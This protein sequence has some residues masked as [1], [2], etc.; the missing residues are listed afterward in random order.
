MIKSSAEK[1]TLQQEIFKSSKLPRDNTNEIMQQNVYRTILYGVPFRLADEYAHATK[2]IQYN[3]SRRIVGAMCNVYMNKLSHGNTT[4]YGI[5]DKVK[6]INGRNVITSRGSFRELVSKTLSQSNDLFQEQSKLWEW[7]EDK[8][9]KVHPRLDT[10][11]FYTALEQMNDIKLFNRKLFDFNEY[12]GRYSLYHLPTYWSEY[13]LAKRILEILHGNSILKTSKDIAKLKAIN[14]G[15]DTEQ[16]LAISE[17]FDNKVSIITGGA[18]TGKSKTIEILAN[19]LLDE[20][21]N[22]SIRIC[23]PTGIAAQ[24]LQNRLINSP[25]E[26]VRIYFSDSINKSRTI[27]SLLE[28][29]PSKSIGI[30]RSKFSYRKDPLIADILIIDE[31]SMVDIYLT[32]SLL[33]ALENH[34]H[35]VIVGDSN[36]LNSIGPGRVLYDLTNGLKRLQKKEF[37]SPLPKW[38][39]LI[40]IHRTK[41]DSRIPILA[42]TLLIQN[43]DDR[44]NCFKQELERC[45]EKG[46]VRYI[47]AQETKEILNLTVNEYLNN[48][49]SM[50][51]VALITTRH[52]QEIGRNILNQ[53][54]QSKLMKRSGFE[55]GVI[56]IQNRNDYLH[57]VFN[58]EK[59][60]I[61]KVIENKII[62]EF[63]GERTVSL[64]KNQAEKDWLIGYAITVHKSQGTEAETVLLPIWSEPKSKIW[65]RS[66]LYTAIT[67]SKNKLIFIGNDDAL[68]QGVKSKEG[69]RLTRLPLFYR[70]IANRYKVSKKVDN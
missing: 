1:E 25:S 10:N 63:I 48:H 35:V 18:G 9:G 64:S 17:V 62:A 37:V 31:A 68:E 24:N 20:N 42:N 13:Q 66:L 2:K 15:A 5:N 61:T 29:K 33:W 47:K 43:R 39:N 45:I 50:E 55:E 19:V 46:D 51:N 54:I 30:I 14:Y 4:L 53:K 69:N 6:K 21:A 60:I 12:N 65:N 70:E 7:Y 40:T 38:S 44:W 8:D 11:Y 28:I 22:L 57:G 52:N 16:A 59:G 26:K 41:E 49:G 23:S 27:H 3:D 67:R 58:G 34:V 36:Q 32:R 56:V